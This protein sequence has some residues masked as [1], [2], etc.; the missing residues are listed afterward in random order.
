MNCSG[1]GADSSL[2]SK[3]SFKVA[4]I[5]PLNTAGAPSSL[6]CQAV[7]ELFTTFLLLPLIYFFF[8]HFLL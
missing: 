5:F 8:Y 4:L 2:G 6:L 3:I 7:Y 1:L